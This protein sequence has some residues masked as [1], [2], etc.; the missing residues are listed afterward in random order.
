MKL[1]TIFLFTSCVLLLG[2]LK[3]FA[4][5]QVPERIIINSDTLNMLNLPIQADSLLYNELQQY[6]PPWPNTAC[7][8]CYIGEWEIRNNTLYLNKLKDCNSCKTLDT[9]NLFDRYKTDGKIKASWFSG[10]ITVGKG[11]CIHYIHDAFLQKYAYETVYDIKNGEIQN[12][13]SYENVYLPSG[14]AESQVSQVVGNYFDQGLFPELEGIDISC[15]CSV[16]PDFDGKAERLGDFYLSLQKDGKKIAVINDTTHP[17]ARE[18]LSCAQ[19]VSKWD[20]LFWHDTIRP[21]RLFP[22][23]GLNRKAGRLNNGEKP[24]IM[25]L[26]NQYYEMPNNLLSANKVLN[27]EV[28]KRMRQAYTM[29]CM[30][31]FVGEWEIADEQLYLNY[32]LDNKDGQLIDLTGLTNI[33]KEGDRI[34]ATWV[35]GEI[36][37]GKGRRLERLI[38][39]AI[40]YEEELI[41]KLKDGRITDRTEYHNFVKPSGQD[42]YAVRKHIREDIDWGQFPELKGNEVWV[43]AYIYPHTDGTI[44]KIKIEIEL[45]PENDPSCK[46]IEI[47]DKNHPY[48]KEV[49]KAIRTVSSW[50]VEMVNGQIIPITLQEIYDLKTSRKKE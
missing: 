15:S 28:G 8:R 12:A 41:C 30:R 5:G 31:G 23:S 37:L 26:G 44:D 27:K 33:N 50:D 1:R 11:E 13:T 36:R 38:G 9:G 7:Y 25:K 6:L 14:L 49:E 17:Y 18:I 10:S 46:P 24:E 21:V 22:F 3:A 2:H 20:I 43:Y 19:L 48:A 40:A 32:L 16:I 4:T 45:L 34:K 39:T 47:T 29:D 42:L 35:N